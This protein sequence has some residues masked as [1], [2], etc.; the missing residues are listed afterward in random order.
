M[1]HHDTLPLAQASTQQDYVIVVIVVDVMVVASSKSCGN[2]E[3]EEE[4][5]SKKKKHTSQHLMVVCHREYKVSG[6]GLL[7][8]PSMT[9]RFQSSVLVLYH[10]LGFLPW[11]HLTRR[12]PIPG[13]PP[14]YVAGTFSKWTS[15]TQIFL[16]L[17]F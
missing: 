12:G 9:S 11:F 16:I 13:G 17:L 4:I 2:K 10:N 8:E 14:V 5:Q 1:I 6:V 7:L 15:L 3:G